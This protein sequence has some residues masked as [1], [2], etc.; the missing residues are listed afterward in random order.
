VT[1]IIAVTFGFW[2]RNVSRDGPYSLIVS[3]CG[4][5]RVAPGNSAPTVGRCEV[6]EEAVKSGSRFVLKSE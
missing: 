6:E 2:Y 3:L 5:R 1:D 4:L